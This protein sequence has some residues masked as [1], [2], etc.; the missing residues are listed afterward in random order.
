MPLT[1]AGGTVTLNLENDGIYY[2]GTALMMNTMIYPNTNISL[3]TPSEVVFE[4]GVQVSISSTLF[5]MHSSS[6]SLTFF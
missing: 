1:N 3:S 5:L 4:A 6:P 2:S